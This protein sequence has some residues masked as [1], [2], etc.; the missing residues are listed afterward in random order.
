M[1]YSDEFTAGNEHFMRLSGKCW[2]HSLLGWDN[3][4]F[5]AE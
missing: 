5:G 2:S 1:K 4:Q 3:M